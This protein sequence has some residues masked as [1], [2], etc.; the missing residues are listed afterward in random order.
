MG[1][2]YTIAVNNAE[3][4]LSAGVVNAVVTFPLGGITATAISGGA[5]WTC[6]L[7]TLSCKTSI[8]RPA[9]TSY[10]PIVVTVNISAS[11]PLQVTA[12]VAVSGGGAPSGAAAQVNSLTA[13]NIVQLSLST[14][15]TGASVTA[16]VNGVS[17]TLPAIVAVPA[18]LPAVVTMTSPQAGASGVRYAFAS[19]S[20]GG[21]VSHTITPTGNVTLSAS[22]TTQFQ[23]T[24]S[25]H[26]V[27]AGTVTPGNWYNAGAT[28]TLTAAANPGFVFR[29]FI[30]ASAGANNP[31][32]VTLN[33]PMNVIA[34]FSTTLPALSAAVM[35]KTTICGQPTHLE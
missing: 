20:D 35:S 34:N 16:T 6:T 2:Q 9:G 3:T 12:A 29:L 18:N 31:L 10:A 30:N 5:D 15:L 22:F 23:L 26:P 28:T 17:Y 25:V 32:Q 33:G 24:T 21:A 19:W 7:A 11:A 1:A 27:N 4:G 14:T 13:P 8:A